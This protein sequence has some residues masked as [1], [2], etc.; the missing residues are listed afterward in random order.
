L[1]AVASQIV[2]RLGV[3][4]PGSSRTAVAATDSQSVVGEVNSAANWISTGHTINDSVGRAAWAT[5]TMVTTVG[6]I[7][8]R[9][10]ADRCPWWTIRARHEESGWVGGAYARLRTI[11]RVNA[12]RNAPADSAVPA[13]SAP[14]RGRAAVPTHEMVA[15]DARRTTVAHTIG[16]VRRSWMRRPCW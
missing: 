12:S 15:V 10:A 9:R 4:L 5:P 7:T 14:C 16:P 1:I 3:R 6:A 11:H 2:S 8:S 13:R